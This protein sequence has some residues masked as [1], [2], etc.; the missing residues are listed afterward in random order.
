MMVPKTE[1]VIGAVL[2]RSK[3]SPRFASNGIHMNSGA[4]NLQGNG[5][6]KG[7]GASQVSI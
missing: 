2:D 7:L 6:G 3:P 1:L 4:E 5:L